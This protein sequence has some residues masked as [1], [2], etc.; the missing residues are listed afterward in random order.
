[1]PEFLLVYNRETGAGRVT[2]FND[3]QDERIRAT[4]IAL[5][6]LAGPDEEVVL[7]RADSGDSIRV[8]Q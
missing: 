8:A 7:L 3:A 4:R 1:M 6:S 5:E 2:R